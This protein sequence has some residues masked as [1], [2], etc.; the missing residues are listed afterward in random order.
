MIRMSNRRV[1]LI[2]SILFLATVC[3]WPANALTAA[4]AVVANDEADARRALEQAFQRLRAGEYGALYDALPTASQRRIPRSRFVE[5]LQR[6][7]GL[8]DLERLEVGAV[9]VSGNLAVAETVMYGRT[10]KPFEGEGKIVVRQYMMREGGE[11]RVATGDNS[12]LK[13]LLASNP[14]LA[15]RY[16]P[17][18]PRVF[19]RRD[20]GWVDV[21]TLAAPSRRRTR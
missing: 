5:G 21:R 11:W 4:T 1:G 15:R 8:Y 13:P 7:R 12:T 17:T 19:L 18:E 10:R 3:A 6:T 20:G 14:R 9:R 16:P 2:G